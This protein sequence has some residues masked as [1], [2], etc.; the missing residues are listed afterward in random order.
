MNTP[1]EF[2]GVIPAAGNGK[3][4]SSTFFPKELIPI[5]YCNDS[6]SVTLDKNIEHKVVSEFSMEYLRIAGVR[7]AY[8]I[9]SDQKYSIVSYFKDGRDYGMNFSYIYQR[10]RNGLAHAIDCTYQFTRE[11]NIV[12]VLP[13][14]IIQPNLSLKNMLDYFSFQ[15]AD[16]ILG[17]FSTLSPMDLC[18]VVYDEN[19]NVIH[20]YDKY[21]SVKVFN[22]WGI[23]AWKKKFSDFLHEY[24]Q[25]NEDAEIPLAEVFNMAISEGFRILAYPI[26]GASF[27]DIGTQKNLELAR[28]LYNKN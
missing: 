28:S 13:D 19:N 10:R 27:I 4:L 12:L 8:I 9:I 20:L 25:R 7:I 3:R 6:N 11:Q 1:L 15:E 17:V 16:V 24:I 14:T 26:P 18:Q 2:I 5:T 21:N 22:T 23:S